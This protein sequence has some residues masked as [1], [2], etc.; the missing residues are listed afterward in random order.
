MDFI[1]HLK[2]FSTRVGKM[3]D[4]IQT[5]EATKTSLIMPFFQLLGYDIFNPMEFVPEFTADVGIKKGEKVDYAIMGDDGHPVILIEAKWCGS[6][7][8]GHD[9]QLFRYFGTTKAKFA[10]LTNGVIYRFYTDLDSPNVMDEQPFF[11]INLLDV[12]D[13]QVVELKKFQKSCFDTAA[14]FDT[15]AELKYSNQIKQFLARQV[16]DP[17]DSFTSFIISE[18]YQGRKTQA[19]IDRFRGTVKTSFSQFMNDTMNDRIKAALD[20]TSTASQ[21]VANKTTG[22][23][24]TAAEDDAQQ[25]PE[26]KLITTIEELEGFAIIKAILR[27]TIPPD[28]L[29]Y[30]D[31][32]SYLGVLVDDN[33]LKW[34]SRLQLEGNKK[35]LT[36]CAPDKTQSKHSLNRVDDIFS[37]SGELIESAKRFI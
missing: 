25:A 30:R 1:D 17:S 24:P 37:F 14:V 22:T 16:V 2:L 26:K 10:I 7:L 12:R 27:D 31:T 35:Y 4:Q 6:T 33:K 20:Q 23:E 9:S 11:E 15:A 21:T 32:E 19:I 29:T 28:R 36:I 34:I 5:E 18:V 3:K 8:N 13:A